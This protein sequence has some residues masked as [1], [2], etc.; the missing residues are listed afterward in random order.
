M[1]D[2]L[3]AAPVPARLE[4]RRR[5]RGRCQW[6]C[7]VIDVPEAAAGLPVLPGPG[8]LVVVPGDEVPPH[9]QVLAEG[10][11]AE[12]QEPSRALDRQRRGGRPA[13]AAATTVVTADAGHD[14]LPLDGEDAV[15]E[16]GVQGEACV[17]APS[18]RTNSTPSSGE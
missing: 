11:A 10:R 18:A 6:P 1:P 15:L 8:D 13:G 2:S 16:V 17:R 14:G 7:R 9:Q 5:Q 4:P 12:Q 3:L